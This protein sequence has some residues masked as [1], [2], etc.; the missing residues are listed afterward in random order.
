MARV[1][2]TGSTSGLGLAAARDL[3]EDRHQVVLHARNRERADTVD[4]VARRAA[5]IVIGDLA[6]REQIR[7][8]GDQANAIG[9]IDAVIHNAAVYVDP[10]RVA[11]P[12]GHARTLAVN[13]LAPYLLTASVERPARLIY[14]SS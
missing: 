2:I 4:D 14:L 6:S 8:V 1:L 13:V 3:L 10:R 7:A 5:G 11:T 12:E 9:A